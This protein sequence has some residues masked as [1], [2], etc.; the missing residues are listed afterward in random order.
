LAAGGY[1]RAELASRLGRAAG[2]AVAEGREE[3]W[4]P[5][6]R[7]IL[8]AEGEVRIQAAAW[9]QEEEALTIASKCMH[10]ALMNIRGCI[11]RPSLVTKA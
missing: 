5:R 6:V 9:L 3:R 10:K 1:L 8:G 2:A 11:H 4:L 7:A